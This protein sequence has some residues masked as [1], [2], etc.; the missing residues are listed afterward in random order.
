M[1]YE[2]KDDKLG[3]TFI[4]TDDHQEA[5]PRIGS[6]KNL[7]KILWNRSDQAAQ[8]TLD[9][10]P[11]SLAPNQMMTTTYLQH[12]ELQEGS[13]PVTTWMFN[14][15]F[16]CIND[17]DHEVSCNGIIFFGT[18]DI[19]IINLDKDEQRKFDTLFEVF[20]D[21]FQTHDNIQ[22]EMLRM[23]LKRVIIICT[24]LVKDQRITQSL[25]NTQVDVIRKFNVLVDQHFRS[26]KQVSDYA[27]MLNKSPKTLSN[28]FALF[29]QQTPLQV[30]HHRI[31]LEAKRLLHY[32]DLSMKEIAFDLG[33]EEVAAFNKLFKKITGLTPSGFKEQEQKFLLGKNG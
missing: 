22:G 5:L 28:L 4:L 33:Y 32:T 24:R 29:N 6:L 30:I 31:V 8:F 9:N 11:H 13:V 15:E 3:A 2:W 16:Y 25:N 7:I 20:I 18:Q 12:F 26:H 10:V 21:E 27:D 1:I 14:R 17:H 23:L 19:P